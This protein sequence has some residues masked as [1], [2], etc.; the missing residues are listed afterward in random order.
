[1]KED[2]EQHQ[3]LNTTAQWAVLFMTCITWTVNLLNIKT[4]LALED[5]I[6]PTKW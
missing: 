6:D 4:G 3:W 1:M 5:D 2:G